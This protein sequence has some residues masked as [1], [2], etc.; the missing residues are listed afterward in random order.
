MEHKS[1]YNQNTGFLMPIALK[2][3]SIDLEQVENIAEY[4]KSV[5]VWVL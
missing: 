3:S 2:S 1:Q 4:P 5:C